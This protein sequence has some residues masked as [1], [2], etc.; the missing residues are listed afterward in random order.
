MDSSLKLSEDGSIALFINGDLQF[1]SKDERI[2]H[3]GLVVPALLVATKHNQSDLKALVIGGGDGLVAREL[4]KSSSVSR[5]ELVDYSQEVVDL[6]KQDIAILNNSSLTDSRLTL[7]VR[8]AWAYADEAINEGKTYD[9]I[10]SDLTVPEDVV[11]A[12]FHSVDWYHKLN[13]LL[14]VDGVI[15]INA[16]SPQ[17]TPQA[18][19]SIFNSIA[20][21]GLHPRPYHV[22]IPSFAAQGF[23]QDWGFLLAAKNI[24]N[25]NDFDTTNAEIFSGEIIRNNVDVK[26]L[27]EF[28]SEF[29]AFQPKA[30]PAADGSS[31]LLHYFQ[32][33][34]ELNA[35][36]TSMQSSLA[37]AINNLTIPETDTGKNILPPDISEALAKS[38][39]LI[40][41]DKKCQPK[42]IRLVLHEAFELM[43]SVQKEQVGEM[44]NDFLEAPFAFLQAVDLESLISRLLKRASELPAQ[45]VEELTSLKENFAEWSKDEELILGFGQRVLTILSVAIVIGNLLYPDMA[46][47]K[48]GYHGGRGG[49]YSNNGWGGTTYYNNYNTKRYNR[50]INKGPMG[51]GPSQSAERDMRRNSLPQRNDVSDAGYI[52]EGGNLYPLRHYRMAQ[53]D[54]SV[55]VHSSAFRLGPQVDLLHNG[56]IAVPLTEGSYFLITPEYTHVLE[57]TKGTVTMRLHSEAD[58]LAMTKTEIDR[59]SAQI[60]SSIAAGADGSKILGAADSLERAKQIFGALD[61]GK[62]SSNTPQV[63][64]AAV[65]FPGVWLVPGGNFVA[66]KRDDASIV[67]L[68][69]DKLYSD[70][71]QT[72]VNETYPATFKSVLVSYLN[73]MSRDLTAN[74]NMLEADRRE[75]QT[76]KNT[77]ATEL[78][79]FE[80]SSQPE[81]SFGT[82]K[83]ALADAIKLTKLKLN[84]TEQQIKILDA[85][86]NK[87][88]GD[89]ELI[90]FTVAELTAKSSA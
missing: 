65:L 7:H 69:R 39:S 80:N 79:D 20:R 2:Y 16:V 67:Y 83:M 53:P 63:E 59:Q 42:E 49:G 57:Q 68:G 18:F 4:F 38:L 62:I 5:V 25:A 32:Y 31:I 52:D 36:T 45:M 70:L 84:K 19:W 15:A 11:G 60:Q 66:I 51:P 21:A 30:I 44:I 43:S 33:G 55:K 85:Q 34:V 76:Y 29:F 8:D 28:P 75:L 9:L 50:N 77:L 13:R 73:K 81:V 12:K 64:S 78:S 10:I 37:I 35:S 14:T 40:D 23:G 56:N 48:G 3:E 17:K 6:A 88:P 47:A 82:R 89:L 41:G 74:A 71:G 1:D 26:N 90:K 86:I 24:I 72:E 54:N 61:I 58:V 87:N 46:Y 27:F 22:E